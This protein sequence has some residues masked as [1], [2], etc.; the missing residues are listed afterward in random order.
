MWIKLILISLFSGTIAGMGIG[1]GS[2]FILLSTIFDLFEHK[3]AQSYNLVM[4]IAVGISA[5]IFN[6][7]NKNV[8]KNLL[9]KL[10]IP[11]CIGSI[12]GIKLIKYI[13]DETLRN[14]FYFFMVIIGIYEIISSLKSIFKAK[15]NSVER[16]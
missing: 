4:F 10:I 9:K 2:I 1:G 8:D 12:I 16:S 13:S 6:L 15:N 7:K 3:Q 11:V 14:S 5:T